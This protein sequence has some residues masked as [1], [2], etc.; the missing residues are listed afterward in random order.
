VEILSAPPL[1]CS[2]GI[3]ASRGAGAKRGHRV[4]R[5]ALPDPGHNL[6]HKRAKSCR[7]VPPARK[8][9]AAPLEAPLP[10]GH[11]EN[12]LKSSSPP[13]GRIAVCRGRSV[14]PGGYADLPTFEPRNVVYAHFFA[15]TQ[16]H[17]ALT[18]KSRYTP[19]RGGHIP[20]HSAKTFQDTRTVGNL[21]L[22]KPGE[23]S[24]ASASAE[25]WVLG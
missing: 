3:F 18:A 13:H 1:T 4:A 8:S 25:G 12:A 7:A 15:Q 14:S 21:Q 20:P 11:C 10:T 16:F 9:S 2:L 22:S 23:L 19:G 5:H 24:N 6:G 17:Q